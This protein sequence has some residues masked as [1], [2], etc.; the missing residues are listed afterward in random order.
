M[1]TRCYSS[2]VLGVLE[3]VHAQCLLRIESKRPRKNISD[4]HTVQQ[5]YCLY[6]TAVALEN[7]G[8]FRESYDTPP[9]LVQVVF[10]RCINCT[11][12]HHVEP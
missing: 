4:E 12:V 11:G 10:I 6:P 9:V 8:V 5:L 7:V 1:Y 2:R 3:S